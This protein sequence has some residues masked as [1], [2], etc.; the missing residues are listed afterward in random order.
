MEIEMDGLAWNMALANAFEKISDISGRMSR[1]H[2]LIIKMMTDDSYIPSVAEYGLVTYMRNYQVKELEE[3]RTA[4]NTVIKI[5]ETKV[6]ED[7]EE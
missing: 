1:T 3:L 7:D 2:K 5:A 6:K 4:L